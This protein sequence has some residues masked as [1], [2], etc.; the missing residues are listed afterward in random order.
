MSI[1]LKKAYKKAS[2]FY[3]I[4]ED[5]KWKITTSNGQRILVSDMGDVALIRPIIIPI[6]ISPIKSKT[7]PDGQ[8]YYRID[9]Y[10]TKTKK[11]KYEF[12]HRLVMKAFSYNRSHKTLHVNHKNFIKNDNRLENLEWVTPKENSEHAKKGGKIISKKRRI[13]RHQENLQIINKGG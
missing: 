4:S 12:I 13:H 8:N 5:R 6:L 11:H 9:V 7:Y 3:K 2:E 10:N 1:G